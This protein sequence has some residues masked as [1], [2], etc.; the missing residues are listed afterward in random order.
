MVYHCID[1]DPHSGSKGGGYED[2]SLVEKRTLTEE[3]Y[4]QRKG[5]DRDWARQQKAKDENFSRSRSRK[6]SSINM[7]MRVAT[8]DCDYD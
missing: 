7:I 6:R 4:N 1:L 2:T 3:D 8:C 5:I